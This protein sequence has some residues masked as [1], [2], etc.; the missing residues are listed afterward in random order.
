M[1]TWFPIDFGH[2]A[3]VP[4]LEQGDGEALCRAHACREE[5]LGDARVHS[6]W[7]ILVREGVP[8]KK[9]NCDSDLNISTKLVMIID[10]PGVYLGSDRF[11]SS[12]QGTPS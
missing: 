9:I 12:R 1:F 11:W 3:R 8:Y 10:I 2:L 5:G 6:L 4:R 7:S